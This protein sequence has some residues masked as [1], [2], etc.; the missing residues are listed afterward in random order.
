MR[1]TEGT[2]PSYSSSRKG[3]LNI[4]HGILCIH[5]FGMTDS[6]YIKVGLLETNIGLGIVGPWYATSILYGHDYNRL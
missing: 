3:I 5:E 6:K 2:Y 4:S 1:T